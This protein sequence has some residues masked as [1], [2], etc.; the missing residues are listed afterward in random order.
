MVTSPTFRR[1][2]ALAHDDTQGRIKPTGRLFPH[3]ASTIH[4]MTPQGAIHQA[5]H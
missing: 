4:A 5:I 1:H 2:Q 3:R